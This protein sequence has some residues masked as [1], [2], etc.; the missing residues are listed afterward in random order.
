MS[1]DSESTRIYRLGER[2]HIANAD[3]IR[4]AIAELLD[5]GGIERIVLDA[6][7]VRE[8]DSHGVRL[9]LILHRRAAGSGK[10]LLLYRPS[11][12][13]RDVLEGAGALPEFTVVETVEE[14]DSRREREGRP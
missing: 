13:V 4:W 3:T 11:A 14:T 7:S 1:P 12:T 6:E 9:L 2:I 10:R 5:T 8:C